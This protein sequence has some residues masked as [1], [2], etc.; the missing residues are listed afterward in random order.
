[1]NEKA[2]LKSSLKAYIY[3]LPALS[4]I[5]LFSIYPIFRSFDMA[6]H[7]DYNFLQRTVYSR[8]FDNFVT[9]WNDSRFWLAIRNTFTFVLGVVPIQIGISLCI[10]LMLNSNIKAKGVFRSIYFLPFVT[11][12]V[13]I[14]MVWQF[15]FHTQNGILNDIIG[16][17]GFDP[18]PWLGSSDYAMTSLIIMS[19][20]R[21]LGFNIVI[22]LAGLQNVDKGLHLAAK[23]DGARA[24]H[25]FTTVT[26]PALSPTLFFISIMGVISSFRVFTEVYNL[27]RGDPGPGQR[28]LTVVFYVVQTFRNRSFG[29]SSAA[30]IVLFAIIFTFTMIQMYVGKKLVHYN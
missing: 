29:V 19:I 16:L 2:T 12:V 26:L 14:S 7:V 21:G 10:A 3:L 24:W 11:S 6:F 4:V 30:A 13:A 17:F 5:V 20:W 28:A 25:R 18:I 1:M 8:G 22:L 23:V 15:V 27:F 9:L